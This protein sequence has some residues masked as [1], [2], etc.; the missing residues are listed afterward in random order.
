MQLQKNFPGY[1]I[2]IMKSTAKKAVRFKG[3][4]YDYMESY[5]KIH[6]E[7]KLETFYQLRGLDESG[8]KVAMAAVASYGEIKM[9]FLEQFTEIEKMAE[10]IEK[11]IEDTR[12]TRALRKAG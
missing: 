8:K 10:N 7:S 9:W 5:I 11:I 12:E 1:Q 3:L 6:D 2:E 4:D